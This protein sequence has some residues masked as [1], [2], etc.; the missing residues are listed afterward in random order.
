MLFRSVRGDDRFWKN[1]KPKI[2]KVLCKSAKYLWAREKQRGICQKEECS[3]FEKGS[4]FLG[5]DTLY[6]LSDVA[7]VIDDAE[8]IICNE[9]KKAE[10]ATSGDTLKRIDPDEFSI[11]KCEHI[12]FAA[13][14]IDKHGVPE[15][16]NSRTRQ[17][18]INDKKYPPKHTVSVAY[19]NA[20]GVADVHIADKIKEQKILN[21]FKTSATFPIYK[22]LGFTV[23]TK[24]DDE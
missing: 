16:Y 7:K 10:K 11:I 2:S 13:T 12:L 15:K 21:R 17:V 19:F 24:D 5:I 18:I 1:G 8:V 22:K 3:F 20:S 4:C 6:V 9:N 23:E 14:F